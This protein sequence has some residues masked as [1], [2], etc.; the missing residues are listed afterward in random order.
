MW[1]LYRL[2]FC[3]PP[4][5]SLTAHAHA[6]VCGH[7]AL[8]SGRKPILHVNLANLL[9][10]NGGSGDHGAV[11]TVRR[12][13]WFRWEDCQ[14]QLLEEETPSTEQAKSVAIQ[15]LCQRVGRHMNPKLPEKKTRNWICSRLYTEPALTKS[16]LP[17]VVFLW[18]WS[19]R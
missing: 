18:Q 14:C 12:G 8:C 9:F 3:L 15:L 5:S 4:C 10:K 2:S 1:D 17:D 11:R 13:P 16:R 6:C 19:R 7:W